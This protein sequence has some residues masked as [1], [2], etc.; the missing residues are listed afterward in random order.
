MNRTAFAALLSLILGLAVTAAACG[1]S[2]EAEPEPAPEPTAVEEAMEP[3]PTAT[4]MAAEP[5][6]MPDAEEAMDAMGDDSRFGGTLRVVSQASIPSLD[7]A[8]SGAYVTTAVSSH[9]YETL[10]GWDNN[11]QDQPVMVDSW[12]SSDDSLSWTFNLRDGMVF[13]D[14]APVTADDVRSTYER[15]LPS[16]CSLASLMREFQ[17]DDSFVVNDDL[18]FTINLTEPTGSVVMS[19]A[20]PYCS[21]R[22][23]PSRIDDGV[24]ATTAVEEW[25]GSGPYQFVRWAQGDRVI[26]E[27]F[28]GYQSRTDPASLYT[29]EVKAYID[30]IVWLEIPDEE[31]KLAGLETGEWDVVDGA[32][33]DFYARVSD[34]ADLTVPLYKPGHRTNLLIPANA[35]FDE[36]NTR[37]A[38]QTGID[39]ANVMASLGPSE[40]WTLCPAIFFCGTRWE[41]DAGADEF[42]NL[43]DKAAARTMLA[44]SGYDGETLVLLN[45]TD[46]STITPTGFVVKS[47]MEALGFNVE[48]PGLDWATVVTRFG[49]PESF[50]VATSWDVHWNSTSPLE[51]EAIGSNFPVFPPPVPRLHELRKQFAQAITE[52]DKLRLVDELQVEFYRNVPALYLGVFYSIYPATSALKNFEVKAFPYY[53]NSW[54]ER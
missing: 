52:P 36:T 15:W 28:D 9:I 21:P 23:M 54:L 24:E 16:W 12:E 46:Y 4:A 25:V 45:P 43:N 2:E 41:T 22:I 10:F 39:V 29:G 8:F 49:N 6:A 53:A 19:V 32:G 33:L 30:E 50:A 1:S 51:H 11:I 35:P 37:L 34:N 5:T 42:Y 40:L 20:K 3:V 31:T 38:F 14:G 7:V 48:M 18:S 47:E 44:D 27:R 17:G 13:H 26:L